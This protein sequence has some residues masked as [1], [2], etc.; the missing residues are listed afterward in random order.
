[1]ADKSLI[2]IIVLCYNGLKEATQPCLESIIAN[3]LQD[4]YELIIVNN[5]SN[6]GAPT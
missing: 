1:M 4:S 6:L 5:A 3:T 2:S